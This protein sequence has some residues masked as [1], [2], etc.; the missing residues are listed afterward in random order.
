MN[1]HDVLEKELVWDDEGH[2]SEIAKSALADGQV[3]EARLDT[4]L[5]RRFTPMFRFGMFDEPRRSP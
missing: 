5:L 2:L 3:S 4:M 1:R